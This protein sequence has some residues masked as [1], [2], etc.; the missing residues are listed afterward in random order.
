MWYKLWIPLLK[1]IKDMAIM[2]NKGHS[3]QGAEGNAPAHQHPAAT[4]A[5]DTGQYEK[6]EEKAVEE[7]KR[8]EKEE[9][10]SKGSKNSGLDSTSKSDGRP[11][12]DVKNSSGA[13]TDKS[14]GTD[15]AGK[16]TSK[17]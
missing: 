4:D 14:S 11:G 7:A 16:S 8:L 3:G 2:D 1:R 13:E 9:K 12:S 10:E 17:K 6:G 5:K 15:S